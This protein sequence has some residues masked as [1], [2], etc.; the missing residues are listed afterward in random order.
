MAS[1]LNGR[2]TQTGAAVFL[3]FVPSFICAP[4]DSQTH[5]FWGFDPRRRQTQA[6]GSSVNCLGTILLGGGEV[7]SLAWRFSCMGAATVPIHT[8]TR[9]DALHKSV[10]VCTV[11]EFQKKVKVTIDWSIKKEQKGHEENILSSE[12]LMFFA[13]KR[14]FPNQTDVCH[15]KSAVAHQSHQGVT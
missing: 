5:T 11:L 2:L 3:R 7:E 14:R 9:A 6:S 4:F 13:L 12:E 8:S 10:F 1:L 15:T